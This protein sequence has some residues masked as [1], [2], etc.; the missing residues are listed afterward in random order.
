MP[1]GSSS[2][3]GSPP[4][5]T[6]SRRAQGFSTIDQPGISLNAGR[7]S[8]VEIRLVPAVEDVITV[9]AETPM[10]DERRTGNTQTFDLNER[11]GGGGRRRPAS[12][13]PSQAAAT[14]DFDAFE[15]EA[16]SLK[17]GLVGGVKPLPIAIP[18][19]GKLL[20]LS[21]VLPPEKIGVELEVKGEKER[22]GW[23]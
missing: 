4:A 20:L 9:T 16:R 21:G 15:K 11:T 7:A 23:L 22:R 18:E 14:Y 19:T 17:Q 10:L 6:R 13:R 1:R 8:T 12:P 5:A 2:T 3:R